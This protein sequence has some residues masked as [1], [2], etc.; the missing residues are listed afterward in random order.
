MALYRTDPYH[1]ICYRMQVYRTVRYRTVLKSKPIR[2]LREDHCETA[3][4]RTV[5]CGTLPYRTAP[6]AVCGGALYRT[7][8][9]ARANICYGSSRSQAHAQLRY[10]IILQVGDMILPLGNFLCC[11]DLFSVCDKRYGH[12]IPCFSAGSLLDKSYVPI[13]VPAV[14]VRKW[15]KMICVPISAFLSATA[16][17]LAGL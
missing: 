13:C 7:G 17:I 8:Q 1:T 15:S 12:R 6:R 3:I 9:T 11:Q 4:Y 5:R 2:H 10:Q 14:R 16:K